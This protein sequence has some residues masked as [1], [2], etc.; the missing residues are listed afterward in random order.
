MLSQQNLK[1]YAHLQLRQT[2]FE[3][4][5]WIAKERADGI[6]SAILGVL[7]IGVLM[8]GSVFGSLWL[9]A[10]LQ[11]AYLGF[12]ILTLFWALIFILVIIFKKSLTSRLFRNYANQNIPK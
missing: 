8:L 12:G 6:V 11:S 10:L 5:E 4:V 2:Q 1:E 9:N 7:F 3:L